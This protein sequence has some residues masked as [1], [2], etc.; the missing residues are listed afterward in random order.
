M[1]LKVSFS[2]NNGTV[3]SYKKELIIS[4]GV[5]ATPDSITDQLQPLVPLVEGVHDILDTLWSEVKD[6][7]PVEI[8]YL[9]NNWLR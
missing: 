4:I 5:M 9:G 7:L 2:E 8:Q 1:V 6:L 3:D